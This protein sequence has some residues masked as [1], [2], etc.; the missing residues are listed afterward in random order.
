MFAFCQDMPGITA[1]Q[2]GAVER[3]LGDQQPEGLVAHVAGPTSDGWRIIDVWESEAAYHR[4]AAD[5]L[6]PAVARALADEPAPAQPFDLRTVQGQ[7]ER[8][9]RVLL[10]AVPADL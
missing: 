6:G 5:R 3:E 7:A 9:G 8:R 10:G 1:E 2:A 4:F